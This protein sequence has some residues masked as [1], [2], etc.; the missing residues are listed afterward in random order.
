MNFRHKICGKLWYQTPDEV[1]HGYRCVHCYGNEKWTQ[2]QF[3]NK[4]KELYGN[5]F[6]VVG[7]YVN[8]H[9]KI[10]MKHNKC[11][12]EWDV[13]PRDIIHK[14]SGALNVICLKVNAELQNSLMIIISNT[15]LK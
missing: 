1:L 13:L 9:T 14:H 11:D 15:L 2:D 5:E 6:T 12:F 4:I 10:K 8:N 7:E 3:E